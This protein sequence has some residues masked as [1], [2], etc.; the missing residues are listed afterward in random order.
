MAEPNV[1]EVNTLTNKYIVPDLVD[2]Y[3]KNGPAFQFYKR[4]RYKTFPGGARIQEGYMYKP[5]KGG[6][7]KKGAQFDITRRQTKSALLFDPKFYEVNVSEHLEDIEVTIRGPEAILSQVRTDMANAASTLSAILEVAFWHHGQL[8]GAIDR[9]GEI[10]GIEE[11]LNDGVNASWDGNTFTSYGEQLRADVAPALT[12]AGGTFTGG[13]TP[14]VAANAG[15]AITY[16]VLEH[17]YQSCVIGDDHPVIGITSNRGMGFIG[18]NFQPHQRI[19][20]KEPTIGYT[21]I[22]F[23]DATIIQSQYIPGQDGVDD[24]DIGDYLHTSELFAWLNPGPEGDDAYTKLWVSASPRY[25][26]G[27]TGFKVA[28]DSTMIAGQIL[29]AC[30]LSWRSVRTQR[31]MHGF[32]R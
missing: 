1:D 29:L 17:S 25:Q 26:F 6:A 31:L 3:F 12:P 20:T 30:N 14:L 15:P 19:D 18:E 13:P 11:A 5:L 28:Q 21:G 10:N 8:I 27:W 4:N 23:K 7:Y 9:T 32:T 22:K 16:R 2:N 24:A